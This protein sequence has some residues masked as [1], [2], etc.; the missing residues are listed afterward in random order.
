MSR[1]IFYSVIF[2]FWLF[3]ISVLYFVSL[4]LNVPLWVNTTFI[5]FL[6]IILIIYIPKIHY[7]VSRQDKLAIVILCL[8]LIAMAYNQYSI[9]EKYGH[10]D[11]WWFWN[12][13][14]NFLTR[15][16]CWKLAFASDQ[17]GTVFTIPVAH[18][19]YPPFLPLIVAFCW[20]IIGMQ[21][22][23]VP[24]TVSVFAYILMSSI[25]F[26]EL[27]TRNIVIAAGALLLFITQESLVKLGTSQ[28]ADVWV[29][30]LLLL[31]VICWH[32]YRKEQNKMLITL[33]GAMFGI[34][35]WVKN[36]GF[37]LLTVF[38]VLHAATLL[39]TKT[40]YSFI[41]GLTLPLSS[42][43]LFKVLLAPK[44]DFIADHH[45]FPWRQIIE[46][47]RYTE[48]WAIT[49]E[50]VQLYFPFIP[51]LMA[52]YIVLCFSIR[53]KIDRL[54]IMLFACFMAFLFAYV[55]SPHN[56][57]WHVRTSVDRLIF[58]LLPTL[59]WIVA[60]KASRFEFRLKT[61]DKSL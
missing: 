32:S 50:I 5:C 27:S 26:L 29:S 31:A 39:R 13:R 10:W 4:I 12:V 7:I 15:S 44:N 43:I 58:Q 36:E 45:G 40:F 23:V 37:I 20:R 6:P 52:A 1:P 55:L 22:S 24:Y 35:L 49:K 11:A 28:T 54:A 9:C 16:E 21:A 8:G 60:V 61:I 2:C 14:A 41:K 59:I 56:L 38:L 42:V 30:L 34:T 48:I 57:G 47:N 51:Y 53:S 25:L 19:D 3:S 46:V 33:S 17:Y 18:S